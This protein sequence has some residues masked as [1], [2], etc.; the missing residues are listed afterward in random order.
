MYFLVFICSR[1]ITFLD[2]GLKEIISTLT[3]FEENLYP[4]DTKLIMTSFH[5]NYVFLYSSKIFLII[6]RERE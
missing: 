6:E 5:V 3:Q 4:K 1:N 2:T